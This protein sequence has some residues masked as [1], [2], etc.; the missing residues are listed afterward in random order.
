MM[1]S[2]NLKIIIMPATDILNHQ[3]KI[4]IRKEHLLI[5]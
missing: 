1:L 5:N 2:P 4:M 3:G